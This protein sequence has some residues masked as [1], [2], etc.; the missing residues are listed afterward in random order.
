MY[1]ASCMR[2]PASG[3]GAVRI[4]VFSEGSKAPPD[5]TDC[6][7]GEN[8]VYSLSRLDLIAQRSCKSS[9]VLSISSGKDIMC[10]LGHY[11]VCGAARLHLT[12]LMHS[13]RRLHLTLLRPTLVICMRRLHLAAFLR[14]PAGR[15][16]GARSCFAPLSGTASRS[17]F[18]SNFLGSLRCGRV[19]AVL[20][21]LRRRPRRASHGKHKNY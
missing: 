20:L 11:P 6:V 18:L 5:L 12:M 14:S 15:L 4:V 13:A 17:L 3:H 9:Y 16:L 10:F 1:C 2:M 8:R 21:M 19:S 7:S